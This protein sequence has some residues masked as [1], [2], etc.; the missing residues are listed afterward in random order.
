[1]DDNVPPQNTLLLVQ[2]LQDANKDFD[3]VIY[4]NSRHGYGKYAAY[5]MRLRWDYFV[6]NLLGKEPP[7]SYQIKEKPDPRND[8][9]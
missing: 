8:V 3:L 4:P 2:A 6:K 1:M 9:R 5:Q 7:P